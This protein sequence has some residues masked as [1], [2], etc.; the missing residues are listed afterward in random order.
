VR[1]ASLFLAVALAVPFAAAQQN[2]GVPTG[3]SSSGGPEP[4]ALTIYN[5]GF[6]VARTFVDLDLRA[7]LNEFT[8]TG[9]TSRLE[10]DS[11]VL[12]DPTGKRIVH[13]IE[14]NY[15]AGVVNQ[16]WLLEKYEGKTIDFQ[17]GTA[18][19]GQTQI[20]QGKIIRAGY[21]RPAEYGAQGQ[22]M[23]GQQAQ[24]LVEVN[25]KMQFQLPGLP[26]FP[27]ATDGLLLKPTLRWQI[28]S[29]KPDRF[30]AELAYITGGL[31]WEATYNV[32]TPNSRD[33][34]GEE[35]ADVLGWVTIRNQSGTEFPQATIKLMA[36]DVSK[37]QPGYGGAR[38]EAMGMAKAP[39]SM[40]FRSLR[41]PSTISI[42]TTS[43]APSPCAMEKPSRCSSSRPPE[44]PSS[45]AISTTASRR[46]FSRN[47]T[48]TET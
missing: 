1:F 14:Q 7:G 41:K 8:T 2:S 48:T 12:R 25:G 10:P 35:Q 40:A 46:S 4:I 23:Q 22:Y 28:Q 29:E 32:V 6:A 3:R 26:L 42:S 44:S 43:T 19:G 24:P 15:D 21:Q 16:D 9:V 18:P 31:D 27:V 30:N 11:V 17:T 34:T 39:S 38:M 36:G 45:A 37:I 13:V 20:V 47:P 33:V 5:Q